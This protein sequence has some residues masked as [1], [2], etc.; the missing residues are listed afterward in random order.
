LLLLLLV[1]LV[2]SRYNFLLFHALAEFFSIGVA[3]A[4]FLIAWN[5]R[6]FINNDYL[7]FLGLA[8]LFVGGLDVLHTL[9]YKGMGVFPEATANLPTQL[10]LAGRFVEAGA[11]SAAPFFID[12]THNS[13]VSLAVLGVLTAIFLVGIFGGRF[14]DAFI[15]GQGLTSF[16]VLSEYAICLMLAASAWLLWTKRRY[17]EPLI[18]YLVLGALAATICAELLF[19]FY[20]SVYGISNLAGHFFKFASFYFIYLAVIHKGLSDPYSLLFRELAENKQALEESQAIAHVGGWSLDTTTGDLRWT[21]ETYRLHGVDEDFEPSLEAVLPF[22]LPEDRE[23]VRQALNNAVKRGEPFDM[24]V[25][26]VTAEGKTIWVRGK[27][28]AENWQAGGAT[29]LV[30]IVQ[31]VTDWKQMQQRLSKATEE[32]RSADRAKSEFLAHM[33][34]E[35]R[36]PLSGIMGMLRMSRDK[37]ESREQQERMNMALESA[38]TLLAIVNDVLDISK[39]ESGTLEL[40]KKPFD[41]SRLMEVAK[42]TFKDLAGQQ[43]VDLHVE[44]DEGLPRTVIGDEVRVRQVIMNLVS[45]AIKFTGRGGRVEVVLECIGRQDPGAA[46][47][48]LTVSDTGEGMSPDEVR[49]IFG[50]FNQAE[51]GR[52]KGGTGLGLFIVKRLV[53]SMGGEINV[54]SLEGEGTAFYVDLKLCRS[55]RQDD[56]V[57]LSGRTGPL[58]VLLVEDDAASRMVAAKYLEAMG[59]DVTVV[60]NGALAL[61][62]LEKHTY[63]LVLLDMN[64]PGQDGLQIRRR[65]DSAGPGHANARTPFV[66]MSGW[67]S[68]SDRRRFMEQ[69]FAEHLPKPVDP[70]RLKDVLARVPRPGN[71]PG[72]P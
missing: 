23:K 56:Q 32:A 24:E 46:H 20:I 29:K 51:L 36:T 50:K 7:L 64:L 39:I 48:L 35:L 47:L 8:Y 15:P 53:Q 42:A 63:D 43:G 67:S 55:K 54:D 16:K 45:N 22:Y 62:S 33:N 6:R 19:T 37:A 61:G 12:R 4:T 31:D 18:L 41:L 58:D 27:G 5:T 72:A 17:F 13:K 70:E 26:L 10:W 3:L 34:H 1:L 40:D 28:R 68:P 69:G 30:G 49:G 71:F 38:E 59:H 21:P 9:A 57:R 2:I 25:R 60:E 66:V 14:P 52:R 11:L 65:V 44:M